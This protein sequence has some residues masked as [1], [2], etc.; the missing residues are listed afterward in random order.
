MNRNE[1]F[2]TIQEGAVDTIVIGSGAAGFSAAARLFE[3][4]KRNIM[5]VTEN[6]N[7]GTSRN[8]GSDKQTY[9]KLSIA[10]QVPDSVMN[11]A[12]DLFA[13]QCVDGDLALCEAALSTQCFYY[14]AELGVPFPHN[15]YGEYIGYKTD[16]DKGKR[17][18]SAGP[19][20]SKLMTENLEKKVKALEIP[21]LDNMQVIKILKNKDHVTGVLCLN[22]NEK[23]SYEIIWC[24]QIILATGGPAGIYHDSVY[25]ASQLGSSGIAFEAGV[26]GKNLTEWQYGMASINPRW[27]VSGT[28]MQVLP[29]VISTNAEGEDEKEFLLDYFEDPYEMLSLIFMKGYQW[30]FDV[31]KI[32]GGS[33]IIDLL[34]YQETI[35]KKR[36]VFL[37]YSQNSQ[38]VDIDFSKL[39][40]EAYEYIKNSDACFGTPIQRLEKMN[41][42]AISFYKD[43]GVDLYHEKLEIAICAQHNNGG[44]STDCY[45]QTDVKGL[46]AVGEVCGSHGVARPG[47]TALNAGQVGALRA[48]QY[49]AYHQEEGELVKANT[50]Y[51]TESD[52]EVFRHEA[53]QFIFSFIDSLES[54]EDCNKLPISNLW[55]ELSKQMSRCGG[56]IRSKNE[57]AEVLTYVTDLI[58]NFKNSVLVTNEKQ[59]SLFYRLYDMLISQ[60]VYLS[61]MI[62]YINKGG[63]S[64]GSSL[65]TDENGDTPGVEKEKIQLN[66]LFTCSLDNGKLETVIQEIS[67]EQKECNSSWR[68]VRQIPSLDN[69]FEVEWKK[70]RE[71]YLN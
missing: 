11:L 54:K 21:I 59:A 10:G 13:G 50:T 34:I 5:V 68:Q 30:P 49:I 16:H 24:N 28:Y 43:H 65:Y 44:L 52:K 19:Y 57:M 69:V 35:L 3:Y 58:N 1:S 42:P 20:T 61:A 29:R 36:R 8:T 26:K 31:N 62:D 45:W 4:G 18:T 32:F 37:D 2:Y 66:E 63:K 56:I 9:Y 22:K 51:A 27:N 53:E 71:R 47:G 38:N 6:L 64:R 23:L 40:Q 41:E 15:D 60:K 48:A 33:S 7:S 46:F 67:Y 14:L 17:A 25:P 39:S 70:Y 55:L 12:E